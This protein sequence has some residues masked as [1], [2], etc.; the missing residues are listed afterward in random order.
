MV[1]ATTAPP[2]TTA[3]CEPRHDA[4]TDRSE[5][6]VLPPPTRPPDRS[7]ASCCPNRV[8]IGFHGNWVPDPA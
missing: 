3:G 4:A 1:P 8:P 7:P 6:V 5:L 2:R